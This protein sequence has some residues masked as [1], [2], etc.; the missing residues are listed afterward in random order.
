MHLA[1]RSMWVLGSLLLLL[2]L[3]GTGG[4]L[5]VMTR[6]GGAPLS[7]VIGQIVAAMFYW[8]PGVAYGVFAIYLKQRRFWAVIGGIIVASLQGLFLL[9]G[10]IVLVVFYFAPHSDLPRPFSIVLGVMALF[11]A[12]LAQLVYHLARSFQALKEPPYGRE[13]RGFEPIGVRSVVVEPAPGNV[14]IERGDR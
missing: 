4:S 7:F 12:A 5:M 14:P 6:G 11:L 2:G 10:F 13:E 1:I 9:M 8:V 3:C